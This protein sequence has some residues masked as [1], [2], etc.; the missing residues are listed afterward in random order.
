MTHKIKTS[1]AKE[2]RVGIGSPHSTI[3]R[4]HGSWIST[5][6][7]PRAGDT[8]PQ[9]KANQRQPYIHE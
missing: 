4:K 9:E 1:I 5:T 2:I 8:N 3:N 7:H 6:S